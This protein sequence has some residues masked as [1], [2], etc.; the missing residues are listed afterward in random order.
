MSI[1]CIQVQPS[2]GR[3]G[4]KELSLVLSLTPLQKY[5]SQLSRNLHT[6][7]DLQHSPQKQVGFKGLRREWGYEWVANIFW[8]Q[9]RCCTKG[10]QKVINAI[11][12]KKET[13]VK[14]ALPHL[15]NDAM[16]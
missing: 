13:Y 8:Y 6:E 1:H 12:I 16:I 9:W 3:G 10:I 2:F 5:A 7:S 15:W 14:T 11:H 4:W